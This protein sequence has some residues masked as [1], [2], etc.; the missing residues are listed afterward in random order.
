MAF[1][2][3][4]IELEPGEVVF[5]KF[6]D[7]DHYMRYT[8]RKKIER[9]VQVYFLAFSSSATSKIIGLK[10][11]DGGHTTIPPNISQI[12]DIVSHRQP[13]QYDE[14]KK[15][16]SERH[17]RATG[18]KSKIQVLKYDSS[19]VK[20]T[21]KSKTMKQIKH[22]I[23]IDKMYKSIGD[24]VF[25]NLDDTD[26]YFKKT[27]TGIFTEL[28]P[29]RDDL[30]QIEAIKDLSYRPQLYNLQSNNFHITNISPIVSDSQR[31][32]IDNLEKKKS[33]ILGEVGEAHRGSLSYSCFGSSLKDNTLSGTNTVVHL[34]DIQA[35]IELHKQAAEKIADDSY[36]YNSY[37]KELYTDG[38][39]NMIDYRSPISSYKAND[40]DCDHILSN[41][42]HTTKV[43]R[44]AHT[45]HPIFNLECEDDFLTV[46][47][48][49]AIVS[50][51]TQP[52]VYNVKDVLDNI[53]LSQSTKTC[54]G[55]DSTSGILYLDPDESTNDNLLK[56]QSQPPKRDYLYGGE[57]IKICGFY[58][59]STNN[60]TK[61]IINGAEIILKNNDKIYPPMFTNY[62][63][64]NDI[65]APISVPDIDIYR[66]M[67]DFSARG[68]A[69]INTKNDNY[70]L[71]GQNKMD[72][73]TTPGIY[74]DYLQK[75]TPTVD[76]IVNTLLYAEL[77]T[78][79]S[80]VDVE[81]H[82]NTYS[83]SI[84]DVPGIVL[85][86]IKQTITSRISRD[87][88]VQVVKHNLYSGRQLKRLFSRM[89]KTFAARG[90]SEDIIR[91]LFAEFYIKEERM[92]YILNLFLKK[93]LLLGPSEDAHTT[94]NAVVKQ[95]E[96][97]FKITISDSENIDTTRY[98]HYRQ[99]SKTYMNQNELNIAD[100]RAKLDA[101]ET[102][103]SH[104]KEIIAYHM[105]E[106]D[107][108]S[109]PKIDEL[110]HKT[111]TEIANWQA[112]YAEF[113]R[114]I[115]ITEVCIGHTPVKIYN[116][117]AELNMDNGTEVYRDLEFDLMFTILQH[118]IDISDRDALMNKLSLEYFY[119]THRAIESLLSDTDD[120]LVKLQENPVMYTKITE[121]L[122]SNTPIAHTHLYNQT[123]GDRPIRN[124]VV[125]GDMALLSIQEG[126]FL[127]KRS[128]EGNSGIW[129]VLKDDDIRDLKLNH[130]RSNNI[131]DLTLSELNDLLTTNDISSLM[132]TDKC[133]II[134]DY[135][136]DIKL[137]EFV[138]RYFTL[139]DSEQNLSII[140][141]YI[142]TVKSRKHRL[143]R[144]IIGNKRTLK[145][146]NMRRANAIQIVFNPNIQQD[147]IPI[148]IRDALYS[149]HSIR[150]SAQR[151]KKLVEFV[152]LYGIDF[153][154]FGLEDTSET[155]SASAHYW[156]Y[157]STRF[158]KKI[159][160]KHEYD[161]K[162]VFEK[163]CDMDAFVG[164][165]SKLVVDG[166]HVCKY[167]GEQ[168]CPQGYSAF[169]GYDSDNRRIEFRA[170]EF[171]APNIKNPGNVLA[172]FLSFEDIH[173]NP[174]YT[175]QSPTMK[176]VISMTQ[177]LIK[178]ISITPH[179]TREDFELLVQHCSTYER[180]NTQRLTN[181]FYENYT[182]L[183][184]Y[185]IDNTPAAIKEFIGRNK[186]MVRVLKVED[187]PAKEELLDSLQSCL[188]D[189][190]VDLKS[191]SLTNAT[192]LM[193][194]ISTL[195][196]RNFE[197][198][199]VPIMLVVYVRHIRTC[200]LSFMVYMVSVE[201]CSYLTLLVQYKYSSVRTIGQAPRADRT[202]PILKNLIFD[203]E[204]IMRNIQ[205]NYQNSVKDTSNVL[206]SRLKEFPPL[207]LRTPEVRAE[208]TVI[209]RLYRAVKDYVPSLRH[210]GIFMD[211]L[212]DG[213]TSSIEALLETKPVK[214]LRDGAM[215]SIL[216]K[217]LGAHS[218]WGR[219]LPKLQFVSGPV[220]K[221]SIPTHIY[222]RSDQFIYQ[223]NRLI[224]MIA[225]TESSFKQYTTSIF[226]SDIGKQYYDFIGDASTHEHFIPALEDHG[227]IVLDN[228]E[229]LRETLPQTKEILKSSPM[230]HLVNNNS[231]EA[232][233]EPAS[234][235]RDDQNEL[236][237]LLTLYN[238]DVDDDIPEIITQKR[239]FAKIENPFYS[240]LFNLSV[241]QPD[242]TT[243][244][245]LR[246]Q[247]L[248]RL[249]MLGDDE[250][251]KKYIAD[252]YIRLMSFNSV[253][254][255]RHYISD[256]DSKRELEL[257]ILSGKAKH[258]LVYD[259]IQKLKVMAKS[260]VM[261]KLKEME[262]ATT[263]TYTPSSRVFEEYG[264]TK[265]AIYR[266]IIMD[267][268]PVAVFEITISSTTLDAAYT[269]HLTELSQ[270]LSIYL[271]G[272]ALTI[273][274]NY[275]EEKYARD[276]K[277]KLFSMQLYIINTFIFYILSIARS[278]MNTDKLTIIDSSNQTQWSDVQLFGFSDISTQQ[279]ERL[280]ML[281]RDS[282]PSPTFDPDENINIK[283]IRQYINL[284]TV[285]DTGNLE[286]IIGYLS[287]VLAHLNVATEAITGEIEYYKELLSVSGV[288]ISHKME[289]QKQNENTYRKNVFEEKNAEDRLTYKL[290]RAQ[291]LGNFIEIPKGES[292]EAEE[293]GYDLTSDRDEDEP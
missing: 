98:I 139:K 76:N 43:Y 65:T 125:Q 61:N 147:T 150:D 182:S 184:Q 190:D 256:I 100:A 281:K 66:D 232:A 187:I 205:N 264:E 108:S 172:T 163:T 120:V 158:E 1:I 224:N 247:I 122:N 156:Y 132:A 32:Y 67:R 138:H 231:R 64:I 208:Y 51:Y 192:T 223:C 220:K 199:I 235:K 40:M 219:F 86:R 282:H 111:H 101:I 228:I 72:L 238:I 183:L 4:V 144:L 70:V 283:H 92:V 249:T 117:L 196:V 189:M 37:I 141:Q 68:W 124:K 268:V 213:I 19:D 14:I 47:P 34:G 126:K 54:G 149:I 179:F 222:E 245:V 252:Q 113:R 8:L 177:K 287:N 85:N 84:K 81:K 276:K 119:L 277:N 167:C 121:I 36:D 242:A 48:S 82:L 186:S 136:I 269:H 63:T 41:M 225:A 94:L 21:I 284:T 49:E 193:D 44:S 266:K 104:L 27:Y 270:E 258:A 169:D 118:A 164:E 209:E 10:I 46:K 135:I 90:V 157:S 146:S 230:F 174:I 153:N 130:T 105:T 234:L 106:L 143:E 15:R 55:T 152:D 116:S 56:S 2:T 96:D 204:N 226:F 218:I 202:G 52:A 78:A 211:N 89:I 102:I 129:H 25:N 206:K 210:G 214:L 93:I 237:T 160:C 131:L 255:L 168:I 58:I 289:L 259:N 103:Q 74:E 267:D 173:S 271:D 53:S 128:G 13:S 176:I 154:I 201:M 79:S 188:V 29:N 91:E 285:E 6:E 109:P 239:V 112:S 95:L 155:H 77:Q 207:P 45:G 250:T 7:N 148:E 137:I 57:E 185:T 75:I 275:F 26:D 83:L 216:D 229:R 253:E 212:G 23:K 273:E 9:P 265:D 165:W 115:P 181:T 227:I 33:A 22:L 69:N 161:W 50:R 243:L 20:Q 60:Y 73:S 35:E 233:A 110:L 241:E 286:N 290:F 28:V 123:I 11:S 197:S 99:L 262:A 114:R 244:E 24:L 203:R 288:K 59:H 248:E 3:S 246:E 166:F 170:A 134:N 5:V 279:R 18:S 80:L 291:G 133:V 87:T 240:I 215:A 263:P 251:S 195:D 142:R 293:E 217:D 127:F 171:V 159:C 278:F 162:R 71:F 221:I 200:L 151:T 16:I 97:N 191:L 178:R 236:L 198:P 88:S 274:T 257:D 292:D 107:E 145:L 261:S 12:V 180:E 175:D 254:R 39:I 194:K 280:K 30:L 140:N 38:L 272:E 42:I 31:I 17:I 62:L 260:K